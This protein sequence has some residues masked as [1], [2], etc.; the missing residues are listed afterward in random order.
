MNEFV[1]IFALVLLVFLLSRWTSRGE[2]WT[3][4]AK[5]RDE[6]ES[7]PSAV[8]DA[9][10]IDST[11]DRI[12]DD[13]PPGPRYLVFRFTP[14]VDGVSEVTARYYPSPDRTDTVMQVGRTVRVRYA[15]DD[16]SIAV[17]EDDPYCV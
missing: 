7:R 3:K 10:V 4:Q 5:R 2:V 13:E 14:D 8:T 6:L 17:L 9:L 15:L 11:R 12:D 1:S 16:P